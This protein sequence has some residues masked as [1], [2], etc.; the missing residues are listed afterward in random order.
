MPRA[1]W[2]TVGVVLVLVC[3]C[4]AA[5]GALSA[6]FYFYSRAPAPLGTPAAASRSATPGPV[7][8][9][10]TATE[11]AGLPTPPG[12]TLEPSAFQPDMDQ[13][14]AQ[15][16]SLRELRANSPVQQKLIT[17]E[18]LAARL[19]QKVE[20]DYSPEEARDDARALAAFGLVDPEFDFFTYLLEVQSEGILGFYDPEEKTMYVIADGSF[21]GFERMTYAHE[22]T[23]VLQDQVFVFDL[24][25]IG[26]ED[27]QND[28]ERCGAIQALYEGDASLVQLEWITQYATRQDLEDIQEAYVSFDTPVLDQGPPFYSK[29]LDFIY[30]TGYE[31]VTGLRDTGGWAAVDR[32]YD[33]PPLSTEQILHPEKYPGDPPKLLDPIT[34]GEALGIGWREVDTGVLGELYTRYILEEQLPEDRAALAAAGWGGDAYVVSYDETSSRT[35]MALRTVWDTAQ[36]A[37]EFVLAFNDYNRARF[38]GEPFLL[39]GETCHHGESMSCLS[40]AA[41][42]TLWVLGPDE[43]TVRAVL[44]LFQPSG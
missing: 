5:G 6:A 12:A 20:E 3:L 39:G 25:H 38:G 23:H 31:F 44:E 26:D 27:C 30:G 37:D 40:Q 35:V 24:L 14:R 18:Q 10:P 32:A 42:E 9:L 43:A 19:N 8:D 16:E 4:L 21:G 28:S 34:F 41:E 33:Q 36:E 1:R 22:Y 13:I 29:Q 17:R 7:V 15:V 11:T 2:V